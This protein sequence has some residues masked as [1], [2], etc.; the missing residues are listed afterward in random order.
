MLGPVEFQPSEMA[1]L[2]SILTV[3]SFYAMR[4]DRV[5]KLSTF[6]LGLAHIA[7]PMVLVVKQPHFGGAL[8]LGIIWLSDVASRQCADEIPGGRGRA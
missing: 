5:K 8:V 4:Q 1:K 6:L 2:L 3:A 7:L